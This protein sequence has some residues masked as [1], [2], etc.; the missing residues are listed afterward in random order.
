MMK[1]IYKL[2]LIAFLYLSSSHVISAQHIGFVGGYTMTGLEQSNYGVNGDF[3]LLNGYHVGPKVDLDVVPNSNK[4]TLTLATLFEMR[5]NRYDISWY[6]PYTTQTRILYYLYLPLDLTYRKKMAE[7]VNWLFFGGPRL[8]IGLFGLTNEHY[9]M[10]TKP[11]LKDTS[12]FYGEPSMRAKDFSFGI[13]TGIELENFQ[14]MLG[15]DFPLTNSVVNID[16]SPSV[17]KQH[18]FR[19]SVAYTIR[20]SK[21]KTIVR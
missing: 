8:S 3:S 13:G 11:Q 14:F 19:F 18:N 4:F 16:P 1:N 5:A 6:K 10:A 7:D 9:Y 2:I 17:L 12:P 15:Y 21:D 20:S